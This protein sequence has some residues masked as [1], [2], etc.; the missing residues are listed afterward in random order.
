MGREGIDRGLI[1]PIIKREEGRQVRD[2]RRVSLMPSLYK[3]YMAERLK[4]E[5][6]GKGLFLRTRRDLGERWER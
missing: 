2:Y 6:E 4:E 3:V 1:V 5:I